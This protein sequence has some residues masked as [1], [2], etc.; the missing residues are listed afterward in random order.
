MIYMTVAIRTFS[1]VS[2]CDERLSEDILG[3]LHNSEE[4]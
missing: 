3:G 4:L 1:E 2:A